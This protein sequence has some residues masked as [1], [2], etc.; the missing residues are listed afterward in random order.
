MLA[1][2]ANQ[3]SAALRSV[4]AQSG[5][6]KYGEREFRRDAKDCMV[7]MIKE[8]LAHNVDPGTPFF[9][10]VVVEG[11]A[12][13]TIFDDP[14]EIYVFSCDERELVGAFENKFAMRDV[15]PCK[16]LLATQFKK[17]TPDVAAARPIAQL[18]M[19]SD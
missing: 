8:A 15:G 2:S 17:T 3:M 1:E 13:V 7:E 4:L 12:I 11:V 5:C 14:F 9:G 16:Q 10:F 19:E 6:R 18:W